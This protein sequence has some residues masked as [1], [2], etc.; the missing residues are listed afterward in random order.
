MAKKFLRRIWGR[1]SKL[2]KRRKKKQ[3]WRKPTGRDNKMREKRKGYPAVVSVGYK[4]DKKLRGS[5]EGKTPI[6]VQN[7]KDLESLKKNEIAI[8]GNI[9]KKKKIEI[10]KKAKEMKIEIHN[11]NAK[12]FLKKIDKSKENKK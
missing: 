7:V 9:G 10:A 4:Q 6:L 3:V 8:V 2:G 12:T 1:Y 5:L 11:L